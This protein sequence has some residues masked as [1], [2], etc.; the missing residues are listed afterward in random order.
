MDKKT[1]IFL[2]TL[3][4]SGLDRKIPN[5]S[6]KNARF[7]YNAIL[8]NG[9]KNILEVWSANGYS[10]VHL[11]LAAKQNSWN[12]TTMELSLPAYTET[13]ENLKALELDAITE[14]HL[15]NALQILP[16]L[17]QKTFDFIFID[18][19]KKHTK[20]FF[21]LC[22]PLVQAGWTIIVDDVIKFRYKMEGFF[23]YL[24]KEGIT[25]EINPIDEDDGIM[26]VRF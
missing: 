4:Q 2:N 22:L 14:V 5:V 11:A 1:Q 21:I 7:L 25:Y 19:H 12:V 13:L 10:T 3:K 18:G 24:E 6:Q 23:E 9:Y 20:D 17:S 26:I 16:A 8:Q 15:W